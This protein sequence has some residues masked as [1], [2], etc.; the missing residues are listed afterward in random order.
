MPDD[1]GRV[2]ELDN[3]LSDLREARRVRHVD[4]G[5]TGQTRDIRGDPL[6]GVA[7]RLKA[8]NFHPIP[9]P[10]RGQLHDPLM[11][12]LQAGRLHIQGHKLGQEGGNRG[13]AG[14][15]QRPVPVVTK[16]QAV[17]APKDRTQQWTP[18]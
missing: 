18:Q 4:I 15:R 10:D 3:L 5:D 1:Q 11:K 14:I 17:V 7:E 2:Q 13:R 6:V 8:F 9:V 12:R 16:D